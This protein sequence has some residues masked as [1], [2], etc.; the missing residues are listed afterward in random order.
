VGLGTFLPL[1]FHNQYQ[2]SPINAGLLT[3]L[4]AFMG[5]TLR[6]V[7]GYLSDRFGGIMMLTILLALIG[8]LYAIGSLLL[9]LVP[10]AVVIVVSVSCLGMGNGAVFQLVPQRFRNEIGVATGVIGAAGGIGGFLLPTLLGSVKQMSGS[11]SAGMIVLAFCALCTLVIL[12][13][14]VLLH[15]GWQANKVGIPETVKGELA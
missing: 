2:L 8:A 14:L 9:P 1:F 12:R 7:G 6:P 15:K 5:S 3:S 4:A 10:M 11:Y 13:L